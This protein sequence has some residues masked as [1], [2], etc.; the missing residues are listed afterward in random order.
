MGRLGSWIEPFPE[1]IYVRP[2]DAWVDPS[3]AKAKALVT[4]GHADHARGGHGEVWATPETLAIMGVRYGEQ[5]ARPVAFGESTRI[6]EVDVSFVP[7][8]HVLGSAQIVL[9]FGGERVVVSGDYKRRPDPTCAPFVPVPCDIFITEATFGL[10]VFRHPDTGSEVD[11]LLQ[12]LHDEPDRCIL[13]GAYAL[14]KAQRLICEIRNRGHHDPIYYHGA[15]ER[16]C[17]LYEELGVPLG[18]LRHCGEAT[19]AEMA[20]HIV[21]CPPGQLNDRWSR[22]LPDPVT[23]MASGWMRIRQRARQRNVELPLIVSDHADWDELTQTIREVA[24]K[25]VWITH[26]RE[27]ALMHWCMTHQ[28]KARELNL[29]GYE[30]EDD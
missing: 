27:D 1:G 2:A 19:K 14:G 22:R 18:E 17:R 13:I 4:H 11:K 15:L 30:D 21:I 5:N 8:G 3:D 26:G 12:R 16:L 25:E 23:A 6:G 10:P 20:G 29:V 9:E 28:I 7:A 24:P